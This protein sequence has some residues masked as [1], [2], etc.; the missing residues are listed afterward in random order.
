[1]VSKA[2]VCA[3]PPPPQ[4]LTLWRLCGILLLC[5]PPVFVCCEMVLAFSMVMIGRMNLTGHFGIW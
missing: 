4:G 1:M 2:T 3:P 5:L